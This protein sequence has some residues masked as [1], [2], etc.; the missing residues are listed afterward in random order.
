MFIN[1]F[2]LYK[3]LLDILYKV[4]YIYSMKK[5]IKRMS[6]ATS[7]DE[8]KLISKFCKENCINMSAMT[9]KFWKDFIKSFVKKE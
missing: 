9:I 2:S 1:F 7:E 3:N 5:Q 6:I 4:V 8:N